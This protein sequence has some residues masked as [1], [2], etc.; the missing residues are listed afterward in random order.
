MGFFSRLLGDP[1]GNCHLEVAQDYEAEADQI[2]Q[3]RSI[4]Q[5]TTYEIVQ[6]LP[7]LVGGARAAHRAADVFNE[8]RDGVRACDAEE[9]E[10]R[11][12]SEVARCWR[13]LEIQSGVGPPPGG[14]SPLRELPA[15]PAA[16]DPR[17]LDQLMYEIDRV[18]HQ[19]GIGG[20][21]LDELRGFWITVCAAERAV[22]AVFQNRLATGTWTEDISETRPRVYDAK[23]ATEVLLGVRRYIGPLSPP[24]P[25]APTPPPV[26]DYAQSYPPPGAAGYPAYAPPQQAG[27]P[28][29]PPQ[30]PRKSGGWNDDVD[31][32][33]GGGDGEW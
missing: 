29:Q 33:F 30:Q 23:L 21:T 25:P 28:Q 15:P 1:A 18:V 22:D 13:I 4:D 12:S 9:T 10:Q 2:I 19:P 27:P 32:L 16:P 11:L 31:S 26:Y 17:T 8:V 3:G 20:L 5:L 24:P 6:A 14:H 7:P